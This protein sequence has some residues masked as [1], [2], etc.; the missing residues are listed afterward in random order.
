MLF[1]WLFETWHRSR[2][3]KS[4]F[5]WLQDTSPTYRLGEKDKGEELTLLYIKTIFHMQLMYSIILL[6]FQS[7]E[8]TVLWL[9]WLFQLFLW[10]CTV[11]LDISLITLCTKALIWWLNDDIVCVCVPNRFE[12][13]FHFSWMWIANYKQLAV[14]TFTTTINCLQTKRRLLNIL[15]K[16]IIPFSHLRSCT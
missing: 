9:V 2:Y 15:R 6:N 16:W 12:D 3:F 5:F 7:V 10:A 8:L 13:M 4:F 1:A 14:W 11:L